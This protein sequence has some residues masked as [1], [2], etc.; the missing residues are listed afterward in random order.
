MDRFN[1]PT[2]ED[3][4][5]GAEEE[6]KDPKPPMQEGTEPEVGKQMREA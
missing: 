4:D 6:S 5:D 3:N 1:L 2:G